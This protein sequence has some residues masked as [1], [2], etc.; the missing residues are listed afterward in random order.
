MIDA[1]DKLKGIY[2]ITPPKFDETKL[3]NDINICLGCGIK[4]FQIRYKEEI[5][6][7][8]KDFFSVLIKQ[9]KKK[10]R[11][12]VIFMSPQGE[13]LD[14]KKVKSFSFRSNYDSN[15]NLSSGSE[16]YFVYDYPKPDDISDE[17]KEYIQTYI[18]DFESNLLSDDFDDLE[19]GYLSYI[20]LDSFINFFIINY[21]NFRK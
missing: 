7:E 21:C 11:G 6:R 14:Q 12:P 1:K 8:L 9:I 15:G 2:A 10:E 17:Q 13:K 18:N 20:D 19:N 3:L 5:T 16:I 4:I